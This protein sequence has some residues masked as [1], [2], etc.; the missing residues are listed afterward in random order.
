LLNQGIESAGRLV[1]D[2]EIRSMEEGLH[3]SHLLLVA[4]RQISDRTREIEC[5]ARRDVARGV[6]IFHTTKIGKVREK[7]LP[8]QV[9]VQ[10]E[11]SGEIPDAFPNLDGVAADVQTKHDRVPRGRPDEIEKQPDG[12]RLPRSVGPE[13]SEDL[14]APDLQIQLFDAADVSVELR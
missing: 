11:L 10:R 7:L 13:E 1:E 12:C 6:Q 3:D 2:Q 4:S 5:E 9:L 8:G 14:T